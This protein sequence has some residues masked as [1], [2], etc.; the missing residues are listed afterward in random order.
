MNR[1]EWLANGGPKTPEYIRV[2]AICDRMKLERGITG[3]YNIHH[4][5]DTDEQI[6][7]NN[8]HY[9]RW[10]IDENGE[11]IEGKY[12]VFI[13]HSEHARWH[14]IHDNPMFNPETRKKVSDALKGI[15]LSDETRKKLSESHKGN[16]RLGWTDETRK[17]VS[18]SNKI[19]W[20][21]PNRRKAFSEARKGSNNPMFGKI[22]GNAR[23][24]I[25]RDL[26]G[27]ILNKF[28]SLKDASAE[29]KLSIYCIKRICEGVKQQPNAYTLTFE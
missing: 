29:L 4:L 14:F 7:Y 15:K 23:I 20:S 8:A 5:M 27:N 12:V 22:P 17:R 19:A 26:N 3:T 11:F 2:K 1:Q 28:V 10:G 18:E 25:Q 13:T 9:E 24:V 21:D 16:P 6:A